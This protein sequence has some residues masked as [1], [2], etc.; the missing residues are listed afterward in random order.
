MPKENQIM[1][2]DCPFT[3]FDGKSYEGFRVKYSENVFCIYYNSDKGNYDIDICLMINGKWT[4]KDSTMD[5]T[6]IAWRP[7]TEP[8]RSEQRVYE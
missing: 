1:E 7:L 8:Y 4:L 5:Y 3:W 6:V 2:F